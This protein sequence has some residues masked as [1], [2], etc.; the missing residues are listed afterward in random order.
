MNRQAL[1]GERTQVTSREE[2]QL[3]N[4]G[5]PTVT[6][7][8]IARAAVDRYGGIPEWCRE[9]QRIVAHPEDYGMN[10][11]RVRGLERI[12]ARRVHAARA[13]AVSLD[14]R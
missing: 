9:A 2:K 4:A 10:R 7:T 1:A 11:Q 5:R 14:R 6:G 12:L 13:S 3:T 8:V